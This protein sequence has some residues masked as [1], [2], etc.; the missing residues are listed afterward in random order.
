MEI[1]KPHNGYYLFFLSD[2]GNNGG[3]EGRLWHNVGRK[4]HYMAIYFAEPQPFYSLILKW[5]DQVNVFFPKL[6]GGRKL[7]W[8]LFEKPQPIRIK[9]F[10]CST[11]LISYLDLNLIYFYWGEC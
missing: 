6:I 11:N 5:T 3:K 1:I 2:Y 7:T 10:I 8:S 4:P 9:H